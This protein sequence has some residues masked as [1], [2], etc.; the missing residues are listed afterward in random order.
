[1]G[2]RFRGIWW[3]WQSRVSQVGEFL[4]CRSGNMSRIKTG[5]RRLT[6][7]GRILLNLK[8]LSIQLLAE[9]VDSDVLVR[10]PKAVMNNTNDGQPDSHHNPFL[11][12]FDFWKQNLVLRHN[13]AIDAIAHDCHKGSIS[14]PK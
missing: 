1:M 2:G 3:V 7:A 9:N 4:L 10:F 12:Q 6:N 8:V 11:L 5:P 14:L 13:R